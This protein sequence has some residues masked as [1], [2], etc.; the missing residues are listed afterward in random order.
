MLLKSICFVIS[1]LTK[2]LQNILYLRHILKRIIALIT[3]FHE[4][5]LKVKKE[6]ERYPVASKLLINFKAHSDFEIIWNVSSFG[7]INM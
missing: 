6:K 7:N 5:Y 1:Y 2:I 3:I 4:K